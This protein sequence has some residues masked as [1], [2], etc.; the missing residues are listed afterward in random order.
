MLRPEPSESRLHNNYDR[1]HAARRRCGVNRGV[2][3]STILREP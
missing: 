2:R 1:A 3:A